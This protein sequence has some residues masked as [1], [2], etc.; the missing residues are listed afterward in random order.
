MD[1]I[2]RALISVSD[3]TGLVDFAKRIVRLG[4]EILSTGGTAKALRD[5]GLEVIDVSRHTGFP[6]LLDGRIKTLH[7]R[8]HGGL[9]Y[10]RDDPDQVAAVR[11][12]D[13]APIDLLVVNLYPFQETAARADVT[14]E[15]A[16]EQIDVGGPCMLR[17]AAKNHRSVTVVCRS[18][19]YDEVASELEASGGRTG[20]VLRERLAL[21]A[22]RHTA[23]YDAAIARY[24]AGTS[25]GSGSESGMPPRNLPGPDSLGLALR[26]GEN[27]HQAGGYYGDMSP[28]VGKLHGKDLS[29]NNILDLSAALELIEEFPSDEG[30]VVAI[31][32]HT[33]PCGIALGKNPVEAWEQALATDRDAANGGI[34][35]MNRPIDATT[36]A[37]IHG[38]FTEIIAAP[39][40]A[41]EALELLTK[42]KDRRL[43][44]TR[45]PIKSDASYRLRSALGG[46]LAQEPDREA[47]DASTDLT[48]VTK[49]APTDDEMQAL[50][51]AWRVVKHVKSNAI[52]FTGK[53]SSLG[54]GAG[55]VSRVDAAR[56]AMMK[57]KNAGLSLEG[58]AVGSD[59][60][61]PFA[62]GLLVCADAGA[63]AVI[64]PGGSVRDEEVIHAADE[65]G[66][67]MVFT[68]RRHFRH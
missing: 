14:R 37:A 7:P 16:V 15:E 24:L 48:V 54:L 51:F 49:R 58:S 59:A 50:R 27:P 13:I 8:I 38:F 20:L 10:L 67:A 9:L 35:A 4:I 65:R 61:F 45:A 12:H 46:I 34:V 1:R 55:Q 2:Q 6:E 39:G 23:A 56:V 44:E 62:D 18:D 22:F 42:K 28:F 40:F 47:R 66:M 31:I 21:E 68:G 30:A 57:A 41:S 5:A 3:K 19:L 33:N 32:K 64:Q 53:T 11:E 25:P 26:Y 60:F 29:Y 63:T 52:V 17:S 36:A 43:I